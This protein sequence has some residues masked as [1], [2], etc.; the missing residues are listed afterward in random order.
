MRSL[1]MKAVGIQLALV[2]LV[3]C[4]ED[5]PG[6]WRVSEGDGDSVSYGQTSD[7]V[8]TADGSTYVV[9]NE[10]GEGCVDVGGECVDIAD[11]EGRYCDD[12]NAQADVLL[13]E[14]G[15]VVSVVCYPPA[16]EGTTVE[17]L[18]TEGGT[19]ELPSNQNGTVIT[20]PE[21]SDGVPLDGNVT[22]DGER[23]VLYGNGVDETLI[24]GNITLAS[25]NARL[26]GLTVQGNVEVE[27]NANNGSI[28]LCRI[29]GNLTVHS[30]GMTLASCE[31][32]GNVTVEGNS[33]T[34][35]NIGVQGEWKVSDSSVCE[36]CYSFSDANDDNLLQEDE[37]GDPLECGNQENP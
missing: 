15:D 20:F 16:D 17:E 28:V 8:V 33:T 10:G 24:N 9:T 4:G 32:Y 37:V 2:L 35:V 25:N 3:G 12:E 29:E 36:G 19:I 23:V 7:V 26:R 34:L 31:V 13:D 6:G 18:Q 11:A 21:D 1:N 14:N 22:L 30:N 27:E 5:E